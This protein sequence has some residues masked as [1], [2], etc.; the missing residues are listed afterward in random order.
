MIRKKIT[1]IALVILALGLAGYGGLRLAF[2]CSVDP[3]TGAITLPGITGTV[4]I[5]RDALGIPLIEAANE[6]DLY[7]A[8]GYAQ[9][10]D[11]LWQMVFMR[12]VMQ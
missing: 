2:R 5:R 10:S 9:A 11:R 4:V 8:T 3:P 6:P 7:F 12:M 1:L